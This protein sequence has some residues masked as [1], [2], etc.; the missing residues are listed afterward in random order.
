MYLPFFKLEIASLGEGLYCLGEQ[1]RFHSITLMTIRTIQLQR[2]R[3]ANEVLSKHLA[4]QFKTQ[5]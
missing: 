1:Q 2:E 4:K 3:K 5:S